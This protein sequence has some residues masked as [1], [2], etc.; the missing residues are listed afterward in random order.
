MSLI[1]NY[2][3]AGILNFQTQEAA[4]DF[5]LQLANTVYTY[6]LEGIDFDDEYAGYPKTGNIKNPASFTMLLQELKAAMPDK[7]ITLYDYSDA[8]GAPIPTIYLTSGADRAGNYINYAYNGLYGT[9][10]TQ[11]STAVPPLTKSKLGAAAF[12]VQSTCTAT[13]NTQ[14]TRTKTDGY[15]VIVWYDLRQ[16]DASAKISTSTNNLY[17]EATTLSGQ[18]YA[19]TSG[20]TCEPPIGLDAINLAGTFATLSWTGDSTKTYNIDYKLANLSNWISAATNYSGSGLSIN[21]LTANTE[22]D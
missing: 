10:M 20:V 21:N 13:I 5:A 8:F 9:Y 12:N 7:L 11:M 3:G 18:T 22:Y 2:Q 19:W 15:G 6:G 4:K 1:G 14:S 17:G 16:G